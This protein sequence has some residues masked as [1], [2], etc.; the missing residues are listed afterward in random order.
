MTFHRTGLPEDDHR[1]PAA[2]KRR[3]AEMTFVTREARVAE[4]LR[5]ATLEFELA[6]CRRRLRG[7]SAA[8]LILGLLLVFA[9]MGLVLAA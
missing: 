7:A 6:E 3:A 2:G 1:P 4:G 9:L 8:A 5:L